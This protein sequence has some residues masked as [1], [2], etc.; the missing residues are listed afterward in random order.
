MLMSNILINYNKC[1][2][3]WYEQIKA[4]K[5]S[6]KINIFFENELPVSNC[7]SRIYKINI[8]NYEWG[9]KNQSVKFN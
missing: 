7:K 8:I 5:V 4:K 1:S 2:I 3:I 9:I 6:W